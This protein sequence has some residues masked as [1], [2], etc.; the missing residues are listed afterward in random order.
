MNVRAISRNVGVAL[1]FVAAFMFLSAVVA[2]MN[3]L[4]SSF[5]PLFLSC[6]LT[7]TSGL[8]PVVFVPRS[9]SDINTREGL[10]VILFAWVLA[11]LFGMMPFALWGGE[12]TLIN[13]FFESVS[14]I[15]TTGATILTNVDILP[16]GLL[17]WRSS[18]HYIGGLGVVLF[19]MMILPSMSTVRLKMSRMEVSDVSKPNYNLKSNQ[20]V[21]VVLSVYLWLTA[22]LFIL[23]ILAGMEPFDAIN[24]AMSTV[25][26]GGFS[27][28]NASI[29]F[30]DSRLIEV[31]IMVFMI[32]SSLH[33][34]LLYTSIVG[35][36]AHIFRYPV[37]KYYLLS[38]LICSVVVAANLLLSGSISSVSDAIFDSFFNVISL[39]ST[40]GFAN[41]DTSVW[42]LSSILIMEFMS[43][44]CGCTGS[45]AGG[46]KADRVWILFKAT[47]NQLLKTLHPN[48]VIQVKYGDNQ[49]VDKNLISSVSLFVIVYLFIVFVCSLVYAAIGMDLIDSVSSSIT[50]MG[51]I[52]P[53]F[54]TVGSESNFSAIPALGK[55]VMSIEMIIGRLGIYSVLVVFLL[56]RKRA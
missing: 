12:F 18:L 27:T 48:A 41:C 9:H 40:T 26:T 8:F 38:I 29:G 51:N 47:H 24:H 45:T 54:G 13:S 46:V 20:L 25:A 43:I 17:F 3:G 33:F 23:L 14:G 32:L 30:Y 2:L 52:G 21:K 56:F 39:A 50:L 19:M 16:K 31:I 10:A 34:G 22:S 42:P 28:K 7:L 4:D 5:S 6:I 37:T 49:V 44:Q 55:F 53:G 15:T 1:L 11:S 35:R 36:N